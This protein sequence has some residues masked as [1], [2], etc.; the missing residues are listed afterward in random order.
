MEIKR[1]PRGSEWRKWDLH[2]HSQSSHDYQDKSVTDEEL[3]AGLLEKGVKAVAITDHHKIDGTRI[4]NLQALA[5]D[6]ILILPGIEFSSELGGSELMHYIG[7]FS[8]NADIDYIWKRLQVHCKID[9][10]DIERRGGY[11]KVF[12]DF[13]ETA[14][15]I[16]E[17]GGLVS[18]HAGKKSNSVERLKNHIKDDLEVNKCIDILEVGKETEQE[19][20]HK[21]VFPNIERLIPIILCSDN[22]NIKSY[23]TKQNLW[24]KADLT[25][26]GLKQIIYEPEE[27]VY[28]ELSVSKSKND[29]DVI[30]RIEIKN[31]N[32]WF[33]EE[34]ILLNENLVTVIGEKGAGK[35]ALADFVALAGGDFNVKGDD[36]GSFVS[37]ALKS[38]KQ[39]E[40]TIDKCLVTIH[41]R[42]GSHN[43]ISITKD[44]G[45]YKEVKKV[46]Y[47]SQS[48]IER[49]CH[50]ER[51]EELQKEIEDIIFQHIP[52]Q[53]RMEQ[54]T[55]V[56]LKK[57]KS[58]SIDVRK[59]ACSKLIATLNEEIFG[60]EEEINS[61]SIKKE[62]KSKLK[63]EVKQL[64]EQKPKPQTE[65]EKSI[66]AKLTLL[67]NRKNT[68]NE[69]IAGLKLKLSTIE[70]IKVKVVSLKEYV[71]GELLDIKK[72]LESVDLATLHGK[73][74]F[75]V[76][77][78]FDTALDGKIKEIEAQIKKLQGTV[79]QDK[80]SQEKQT[81]PK[82][83]VLDEL[84]D[85]SVSA[86]D[87]NKVSFLI[88]A[89][90]SKSSVVSRK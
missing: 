57:L 69:Q 20:Y 41:W 75:S 65:E 55:F 83:A 21:I 71:Q 53:D 50:P 11:E 27:L 3:I 17:L 5:K 31:S 7:I 2:F 64:E 54:T 59:T 22:H 9:D 35:T 13:K 72:D 77:Q 33:E 51:A 74:K 16:H 39:I 58:K 34:P 38:T 10:A 36:P 78:D 48:F 56:E 14:K 80:D 70:T 66:E 19:D 87:F 89:L 15:L 12:C 52:I 28:I 84:T 4:K 73:L 26:E 85:A 49:K 42:D 68:L 40:E 8:E 67:N 18:V 79:D 29:A 62:E 23:S 63:T 82:Q 86:L 1:F 46:R 88:S 24:I 60:L 6:K 43:K 44:F 45:D 90:E 37:K 30:D 76:E 81:E 25:F 47:L 61:L 32:H